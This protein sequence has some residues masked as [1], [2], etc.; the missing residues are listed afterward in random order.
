MRG[1]L[2]EHQMELLSRV[3][4]HGAVLASPFG[5]PGEDS[6]LQEVQE[7]IDTL[8]AEG[9]ITVDRAR[10]SDKPERISLT[11]SGYDALDMA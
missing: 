2:S 9:L 8:E 10:G 5:H 1:D 6:L 11:P 3:L 7:D 4:Q